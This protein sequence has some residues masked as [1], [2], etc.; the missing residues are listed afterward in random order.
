[1]G[2]KTISL[3]CSVF[4]SLLCIAVCLYFMW[5]GTTDMVILSQQVSEVK[6]EIKVNRKILED[7]RAEVDEL[8]DKLNFL[9]RELLGDQK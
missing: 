4:V 1:M 5:L 9:E 2:S 7:T 8:M 3:I 6:A